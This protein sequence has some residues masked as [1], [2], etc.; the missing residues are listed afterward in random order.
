MQDQFH[1]GYT[2]NRYSTIMDVKLFK[3]PGECMNTDKEENRKMREKILI[4]EY[5]TCVRCGKDTKV[6]KNDNVMFRYGYIE[7]AGQLCF[8][9][10]QTHKIHKQGA[11]E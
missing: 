9:C 11:Y 6:K 7:G 10:N 1:D 2:S 4:P 5:E 3:P 8:M